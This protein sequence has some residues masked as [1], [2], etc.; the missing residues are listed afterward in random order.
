MSRTLRR[1]LGLF[2]LTAAGALAVPGAASA[3]EAFYGVTQDNRLVTFQSDNVTNVEPSH[4]I[5]GLPGGENI[6]GLDVRPLNG[7]LYALGKTS[8]LYVIN[9]RT[10]AARQVGATPFIPALAGAS[11]GF[12]FNPTVD[13]IRVTSDAEQNLRLD[14]D[15]GTVTGVDTNLAYA[16]GD[17]GAGTNPNVGASAYTNS[18]AGATSTTLFDI[19]NARHA[20]VIQNPPNDGTL[21][22]VGAL[23]TSNNAVAFDIGEGNVGYAVLNGEQNRQ[24]LFRIDLT[25]GHATHATNFFIGSDQPLTGLAAAGTVPDDNTAPNESIALSSTQLRER[26][27][28]VGVRMSVACNEA[29]TATAAVTFAGR[30]SGLNGAVVSGGPGRSTLTVALNQRTRDAIRRANVR[31]TV[32]ITVIDGAGN[33]S[34]QTR[35]LRSQTLGQR[36]G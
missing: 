27:L 28:A 18:F 24:N 36:R 5:T 31:L 9:P 22:T 21:T 32:R 20:L 34:R 12:D 7:Q 13:R 25:N 30:P 11:F 15:D 1:T 8:R 19:D 26:L 6:V 16:A 2:A 23:G 3:A 35:V 17:P 33:R 14:P 10:G 29:C 4:A